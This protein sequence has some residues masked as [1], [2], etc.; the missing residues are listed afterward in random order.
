MKNYLSINSLI[1]KFNKVLNV[2]GD[3]SLSIRWVLLAS[4]AIGK[5]KAYNLLESDDVI[6]AIVSMR[7]LGVKILKKKDC[8]EINGVGLS[9]FSHKNNLNL[10][11]GN[12]GTFAR[13]LCGALAGNIMNV[14]V[15]GDSSLS[16]R[17]F[18]RVVKPLELFGINIKTNR[19]KMPIT[20][21]GSK[22][23]RPIF[24]SEEK[25]S[26]QVKSAI[27]LASL[28]TPGQTIVK[29]KISRNHTEL[30][31]KNCLNIPM[32]LKKYKNYEI[33]KVEGKTNY[34]GFNYNIPGDISS[35][36]FFI[37]L[38]ILANKSSIK[39]KNVNYNKSRIGI[40]EILKKMKAKIKITNIKNYKGEKVADI[41]VTSSKNLIGI[42]CPKSLNT[43]SIDEFLIIFLICAKAKGVSKF[44]GISEL[45]Q[46]E[47][48]RL[49]MAARILRS[50]GI[51]VDEK[52]DSLKIYGNPNLKIKKKVIIKNFLKDHRVFMMSCVAALTLGGDFEIYDKNSINSSFPNFLDLLKKLGAKIDNT[53]L[54]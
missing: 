11:A 40:I 23:L 2:P 5:S 8:Y 50:I 22:F 12:S 4:Q 44:I 3:K 49:K 54:N 15:T 14:K 46:K 17:D 27:L 42:N 53:H 47:S 24:Y 25:G 43:K 9:G 38:T 13:L 51:N 7:K 41:S 20:I 21:R 26:A 32:K 19:N 18:S 36:A 35:A 48:D 33:I 16:K 10:D 6:N 39:M 30:M 45:R 1:P 28:N 29:S 52:F 37:A 34:K 31:F